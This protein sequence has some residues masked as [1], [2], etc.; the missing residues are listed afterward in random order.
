[1]S[2]FKRRKIKCNPYLKKL[3]QERFIPFKKISLNEAAE[4]IIN[5]NLTKIVI[6]DVRTKREYDVAH[7]KGAINIDINCL[8]NSTY[9]LDKNS[10]ILL[11]CNSGNAAI[12]AA[13]LLYYMGYSKIYIW[14]GGSINSMIS[15]NLVV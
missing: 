15:Y 4:M 8:K 14:E 10:K 3:P 11:Y 9:S 2:I 5:K 7:I 1:M 13:Y 6:I 12:K